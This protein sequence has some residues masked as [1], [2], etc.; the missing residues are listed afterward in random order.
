MC[1][2]RYVLG[3]SFTR[4]AKLKRILAGYLVK[5]FIKSERRQPIRLSNKGGKYLISSGLGIRS[6]Y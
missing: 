1:V 5:T 2:K 3:I 6:F 4:K